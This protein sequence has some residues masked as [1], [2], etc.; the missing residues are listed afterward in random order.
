MKEGTKVSD[1]PTIG[2]STAWPPVS[3][4]DPVSVSRSRKPRGAGALANSSVRPPTVR[5]KAMPVWEPASYTTTTGTPPTSV[6]TTPSSPPM[7]SI[8]K[9]TNAPFASTPT[10]SALAANRSSP[11]SASRR[12]GCPMRTGR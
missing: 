4:V 1:A 8:G 9:P 12:F 6:F 11:Q 2:P 5:S 7:A 3:Q 10:T